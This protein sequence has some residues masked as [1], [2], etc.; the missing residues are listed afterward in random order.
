MVNILTH[1]EKWLDKKIQE[2]EDKSD[3]FKQY[4]ASPSLRASGGHKVF[5][6]IG[7]LNALVYSAGKSDDENP[8]PSPTEDHV[9]YSHLYRKFNKRAQKIL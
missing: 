6:C 4:E 1:L 7:D 5:T 3:S 2:A 9:R 8:T